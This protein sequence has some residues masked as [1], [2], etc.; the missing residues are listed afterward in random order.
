MR[1]RG[2]SSLRRGAP[3]LSIVRHSAC[4]QLEQKRLPGATAAPQAGQV[5][6]IFAPQLKQNFAPCGSC[7]WH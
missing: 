6:T 7:A 4:P 2:G 1:S 5:L 3:R